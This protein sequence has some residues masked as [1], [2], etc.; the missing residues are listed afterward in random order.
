MIIGCEYIHS[1]G[2]V[3]RDLKLSNLFIT[4]DMRLKI[5]DFGL[6]AFISSEDD[7]KV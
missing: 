3:H 1:L 5:G 7:K 2:V 4:N 6:S